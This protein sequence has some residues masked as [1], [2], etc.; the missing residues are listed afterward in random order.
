M[1]PDLTY[2]SIPSYP[3]SGLTTS[4]QNKTKFKRKTKPQTKQRNKANKK[5]KQ[6]ESWRGSCSVAC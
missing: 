6:E 1:H 3:I 5:S 2:L 4:P